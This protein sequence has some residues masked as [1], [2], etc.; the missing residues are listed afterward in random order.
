MCF[1]KNTRKVVVATYTPAEM[2]FQIPDNIDL[3]DDTVVENWDVKYGTLRIIYVNGEEQVIEKWN[4]QDFDSQY[5][6]KI[7]IEDG[8]DNGISYD[9][10]CSQENCHNFVIDDEDS[11]CHDCYHKTCGEDKCWCIN[12]CK[13]DYNDLTSDEKNKFNNESRGL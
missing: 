5:A 8:E 12:V 6:K 13:T 4:E 2:V 1:T 11:L 3:N 7:E 9:I 10:V